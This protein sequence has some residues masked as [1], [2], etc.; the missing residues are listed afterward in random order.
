MVGGVVKKIDRCIEFGDPYDHLTQ[1]T[2]F[3]SIYVIYHT[4]AAYLKK[5]LKDK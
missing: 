3:Y 4:L 1:I 5:N 2:T